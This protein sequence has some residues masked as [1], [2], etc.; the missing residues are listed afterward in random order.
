MHQDL[1]YQPKET[2]MS[3]NWRHASTRR[4]T[5]RRCSPHASA[6]G[7][8]DHFLVMR[9]HLQTRHP[10]TSTFRPMALPS[11]TRAGNDPSYS[12]SARKKLGS[13]SAH[14]LNEPSL[15]LNLGLINLGLGSGSAK[16][17]RLGLPGPIRRWN[18][19]SAYSLRPA[20]SGLHRC[21]PD[22]GAPE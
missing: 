11:E 9:L 10:P 22:S 21:N 16:K 12:G 6:C 5:L 2:P 13:G 3:T 18:E 7:R 8:V 17:A 1:I 19:A 20:G 4:F 14:E 15:S